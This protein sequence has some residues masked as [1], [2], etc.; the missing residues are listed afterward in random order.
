V[1]QTETEKQPYAL[2]RADRGSLALAGLWKA[3]RSS[4][5]RRMLRTHSPAGERQF[6]NRMPVILPPEA[7][8]VWLGERPADLSQLK[9]N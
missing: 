8:P 5:P 7:W 2:A 4:P 3:L 9:G 1:A 6:H